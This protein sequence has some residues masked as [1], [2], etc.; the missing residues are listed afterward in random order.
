MQTDI[1]QRYKDIQVEHP[2]ETLWVFYPGHSCGGMESLICKTPA[3]CHLSFRDRLRSPDSKS[4]Q[5]GDEFFTWLET[6]QFCLHNP[7][8]R[9][10]KFFTQTLIMDGVQTSQHFWKISQYMV[11][12]QEN[13][14]KI[15]PYYIYFSNLWFIECMRWHLSA[16]IF[17]KINYPLVIL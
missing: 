5:K 17:F 8:C 1:S 15:V 3:K 11:L 12:N 14:K 16:S 6:S 4:G 10:L 2:A 9:S 13:G 7:H